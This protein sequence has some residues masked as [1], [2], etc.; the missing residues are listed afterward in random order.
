MA[1]RI[2]K[3]DKR[4]HGHEY[5][6]YVV[7]LPGVRRP[8]RILLFNEV[9]AWCVDTWG[10]ACEKDAYLDLLDSNLD[11]LPNY[12]WV[13]HHDGFSLHFKIFLASEKELMW[14]KLRWSE[15]G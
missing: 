15:H 6:R 1:I 13:W 8:Q 12:K 9:R 14:F 4:F 7:D 11:N 3:T 2:R 5:F 10:L